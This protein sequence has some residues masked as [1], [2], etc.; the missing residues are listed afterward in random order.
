[1][2]ERFKIIMGDEADDLNYSQILDYI[3]ILRNQG[4]HAKSL[5]NNLSAIKIYFNYL[6]KVGKRK[7]HPCSNLYLKDQVDRQVHVESLYPKEKLAEF[8]QN[9]QSKNP[10]NQRRNKVLISLLIYQA[11]TVL[12][13]SQL[14]KEE[15]NTKEGTIEIKGNKKNKGRTLHLKP[16]QILL[17]HNY[18]K[19]DWKLYSKRQKPKKRTTHFILN[20]NGQAIWTGSINRIINR[21]KAKYE[22]LTPIKIRQSVITHLL[23]EKNDVRIVQEFAGHR[24]TSSTEAYKQT[25]LEELKQAIDKLHPLQ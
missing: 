21:G 23:K 18:L 3:G 19:E 12:E 8:Y 10:I 16:N 22:K 9:Y 25:G 15:V 4:L 5:R 14:K 7:E 17:I 2:I 20:E 6:L 13:I 11:L 24:R 1:M